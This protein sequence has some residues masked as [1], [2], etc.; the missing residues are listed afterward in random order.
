[1]PSHAIHLGAA[2]EPP[3]AAERSWIRRFGR[4]SGV[5]GGD[6]LVLRCEGAACPDAWRRATLNGRAVEWRAV[7]AT[8]LDCDV[9]AWIGDRNQL[10]LPAEEHEAV[11]D[12]VGGPR[13][14]LPPSWGRLSLL[15]VSD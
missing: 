7:D 5:G 9:T 1:M 6:R 13:V 11:G 4:P 10:S 3:S 12:R 2:W 14:S 8:V 15:V